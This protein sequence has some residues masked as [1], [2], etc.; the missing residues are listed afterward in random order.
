MSQGDVRVQGNRV[1]VLGPEPLIGPQH[2][3][4][5]QTSH[6]EHALRVATDGLRPFTVDGA[7]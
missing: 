3:T 5:V 2:V 7:P 6:P 1:L 4:L